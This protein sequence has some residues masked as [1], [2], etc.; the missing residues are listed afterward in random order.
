MTQPLIGDQRNPDVQD[1]N[2]NNNLENGDAGNDD[3]PMAEK[4][5]NGD[6]NDNNLQGQQENHQN[7]QPAAV[8]QPNRDQQLPEGDNSLPV[9]EIN[10]NGGGPISQPVEDQRP[11][12]IIRPDREGFST[13]PRTPIPIQEEGNRLHNFTGNPSAPD[14]DASAHGGHDGSIPGVNRQS[15]VEENNETEMKQVAGAPHHDGSVSRNETGNGS[16]QRLNSE[17]ERGNG[18]NERLESE[19]QRENASNERLKL[20]DESRN[21]SSERL[22]SENQSG[23]CPNDEGNVISLTCLIF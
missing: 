7:M 22:N 18:N 15:Q 9:P 19:N 10:E 11:D 6:N 13:P 12:M 3:I 1:N 21:G 20:E 4:D 14:Y 8:A 23:E 17:V 2:I 5:A 16:D